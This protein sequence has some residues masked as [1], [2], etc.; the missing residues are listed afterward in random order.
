MP[1]LQIYTVKGGLY[2]GLML[3]DASQVLFLRP[4]D[5]HTH[6]LICISV[7]IHVQS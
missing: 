7:N 2:Q 5:K 1:S 3:G 6:H 4:K